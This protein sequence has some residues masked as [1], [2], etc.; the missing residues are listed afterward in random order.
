M[1]CKNVSFLLQDNIEHVKN[2]IGVDHIGMGADYDGLPYNQLAIGLED[3]STYPN[4]FAKLLQRPGWTL[5]DV[6]KVRERVVK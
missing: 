2:L 5:D 3:V 4:L 1:S 6:K